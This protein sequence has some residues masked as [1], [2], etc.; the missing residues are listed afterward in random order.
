MSTC[1]YCSVY[2]CA[3]CVCLCVHACVITC[4][5]LWLYTCV[6]ICLCCL[7]TSHV[8]MDVRISV[9]THTCSPLTFICLTIVLEPKGTAVTMS[10]ITWEQ[11]LLQA[12]GAGSHRPSARNLTAVYF[13]CKAMHSRQHTLPISEPASHPDLKRGAA[14]LTSLWM[15]GQNSRQWT[16]TDTGHR[17]VAQ[18][19]S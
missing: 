16:Q 4:V 17:R 13:L 12:A 19:G 10:P 14:A 2:T 7:C 11:V 9:H 8:Y 18:T 6:Y 15:D 1:V 3:V 5:S